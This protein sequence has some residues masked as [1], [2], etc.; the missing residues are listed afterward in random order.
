MA[1]PVEANIQLQARL[2]EIVA[3]AVAAAWAALPSYNRADVPGWLATV[4]PLV[5]A[6]QRQ[7][8]ALTD[9]YLAR[10]LDRPPLG[11]D[12]TDLI[13]AAV[14]G[15]T[16]PETVYTRPFIQTWT[17]LG[18]GAM[19]EDAVAQGLHRA[20]SAA[21]MDVQRSHFAAYAAAQDADP[22]IRGY[23]RV[24]D[25]SACEFCRMINGAFVKSATASPLHNGCGC[26]LRP[27]TKDFAP[28]PLPDGV[29][30]HEHG[31]LGPV[32]AAPGD[33]FTTEADFA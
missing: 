11:L 30:V 18:N 27:V 22:G 5:A 23:E 25:A 33:H 4:L 1:T 28:T 10:A 19:Y 12:P 8:V 2:R 16:A 24:A 13:G 9:A 20:Q 32:L 6:G 14:R 7:A 3:A 17:A 31:E 15:G 29:A 21:R 26:G